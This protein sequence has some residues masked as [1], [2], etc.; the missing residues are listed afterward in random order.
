[1]DEQQQRIAEDL[2]GLFQGELRFDDVAREIYSMDAGIYQIR[3]LGVVF[4]R[5]RDDVIS[6]M[7]YAAEM[8]IPVTPR[9]SGS[10]LA[11]GALGRGLIVD[12][13]RHMQRIEPLQGDTVRVEAGVVR[14]HL[15]RVLK[16]QGR[17][18][19]PDPFNT[20][21]T[22]CGGML[23]VDAGGSHAARVGSVRDHVKSIECVLADGTVLEA[24]KHP[25]EQGASDPKVADL[26]SKLR[27][28]LQRNDALIRERQPAMIRNSSG[29]HLRTAIKGDELNLPRL[30]VGSEGTLALFTAATLH[31]SPLPAHRGAALILFHD[32]QR[33]I[34]SV[35]SISNQLP[36]ACDLLDRR[37]LSLIREED[38]RFAQLIP[39]AA[40]AAVLVEQT[41]YTD[42]EARHRLNQV[43]DV[44]KDID[45]SVLV[46]REAYDFDEVEFLWSLPARVVP[47]LNRLGGETRPYPVMED[48]AVP[49]T[50]L[51]EFLVKAQRVFQ[52]HW[53]TASLY[54][55]AASGQV[56]FRPFLK[57][58]SSEN[59]NLIESLARELYETAIACGGT[60]SGEH[61]N[62]LARTAF[63]RSQY[64]PLYKVFQEVKEL[65]D[66]HN[67]LNPG[68]II[69]D[70]PHLTIR[71]FR[72]APQE[73]QSPPVV[74]LQLS[75]NRDEFVETLD[76]CSG[77]GDCRVRSASARM[78]PFFRLDQVEDAAPRSKATLMR[79][80]AAGTLDPK[81]F[82]SEEA[83]ELA[84]SCFNCKQCVME[85]P[86]NVDIPALAIEI[87]AQCVAAEGL[88]RADWLLSR[89]H[90][91]GKLG[92]TLAPLANWMLGNGAVRRLIE[93]ALGISQHRRLPRFARRSFLDTRREPSPAAGQIRQEIV[94]FVDHFANFHDP[95]LG[96]SLLR[97]CQH[98]GIAVR[99]PDGQV[100]S[101]MALI[102]AGDLDSARDMAETNIRILAEFAREGIP[103]VCTEPTAAMCLKYE[104]PRLIRHPDVE[105][106][107][108]QVLEAGSF[109]D[110][111]RQAGFLKLDFQSVPY[112]FGYH[113]PCHLRVLSPERPLLSLLR[114]IPDIVIDEIEK[115]CSGMAG[116]YGLSARNY[117]SSLLIGEGLIV[118]TLRPDLHAGLTECSSCRMQMEQRSTLSTIH[119]LKLIAHAYGLLPELKTRLRPQ[120]KGLSFSP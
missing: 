19:A 118:E 51:H 66:P 104:Y 17:Y 103:I 56:H 58:P 30:L 71:D 46:A 36:S 73:P 20:A 77:C 87:K 43:I 111:L 75:W 65:F 38:E 109:L 116:A 33:A 106:V 99:V 90:A 41:G 112:H 105:I 91:V 26:L 74:P 29:Y 85:C 101:G 34:Q 100:P 18:F 59:A 110:S 13:S 45:P 70:D 35:N 79:A 119:P 63:I 47:L 49:P 80:A 61:G 53:V 72:A 42:K 37:L 31:T 50:L 15:N 102:S 92:C 48:I 67:L 117:E 54:A 32:L 39:P 25:P 89:V 82:S 10:G 8:D 69:S 86:S 3:P 5:H 95:E 78:C 115:G 62:G 9:G 12:F 81:V 28:L 24:S 52:K 108:E 88:T 83:R 55:H 23:A 57:A 68:K 114:L 7:Q 96:V 40:E 94:Y 2:S 21:V 27:Q 98:N 6:L 14:D 93:Y 64:G 76:R 22:T 16:R 1:M 107:A 120:R 84:D 44:V 4:P 60:I 97:I 113:T 11:G